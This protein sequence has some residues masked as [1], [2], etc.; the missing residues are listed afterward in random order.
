MEPRY[1]MSFEE[2]LL[3]AEATDGVVTREGEVSTIVG[4]Y[5]GK[6]CVIGRYFHATGEAEL[7]CV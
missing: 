3:H 6:E 4:D 2:F 1:E 7:Y 5:V